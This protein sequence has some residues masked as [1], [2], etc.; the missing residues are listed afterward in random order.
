MKVWRL[1]LSAM[2]LEF[3]WETIRILGCGCTF[4]FGLHVV[5]GNLARKSAYY[6]N[7]LF[8]TYILM[9]VCSFPAKLITL[10]SSCYMLSYSCNPNLFTHVKI[11]DSLSYSLTHVQAQHTAESWDSWYHSLIVMQSL[12][13]LDEPLSPN[14]L[15]SFVCHCY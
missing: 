4:G 8:P 6:M 9:H 2:A 7:N 12:L 11:L 1:V 5:F 10:P 14:K 15:C 13:T 3:F